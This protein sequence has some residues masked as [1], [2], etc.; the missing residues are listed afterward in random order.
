MTV[1]AGELKQIATKLQ[2]YANVSGAKLLFALTSPMFVV[3]VFHVLL[4]VTPTNVSHSVVARTYMTSMANLR[5]DQDVVELNV[6]AKAVMKEL[7]IPT[8]DLHS[9][10][11]RKCGIVPQA[12]CLGIHNCFSPHCTQVGYDWLANS[13]V[14]PA[15]D[16]L[17]FPARAQ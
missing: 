8:V 2:A 6:R 13:T 14:V 11:V 4:P 15:L 1:Y 12:S 5:A 17:V 7:D 3:F 9:A 16:K 10:I